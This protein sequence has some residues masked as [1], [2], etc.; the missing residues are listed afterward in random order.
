M[1]VEMIWDMY[2]KKL[3][4]YIAKKVSDPHEA[5]DILQ[6]VSLKLIKTQNILE[7]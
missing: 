5:E 1:S 7:V 3:M 6:E 2:H 4:H